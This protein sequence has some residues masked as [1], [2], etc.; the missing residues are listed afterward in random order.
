[1]LGGK[2]FSV[3][4]SYSINKTLVD[5]DMSITISGYGSY[6]YMHHSSVE[7]E[8]FEPEATIIGVANEIREKVAQNLS[9]AGIDVLDGGIFIE[10]TNMNPID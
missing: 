10:I 6:E 2:S 4:Y 9:K 5:Q 7:L 8:A 1:M 3:H